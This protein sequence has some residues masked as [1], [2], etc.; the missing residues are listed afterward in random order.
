MIIN[1]G[2]PYPNRRLFLRLLDICV[3]GMFYFIGGVGISKILTSTFPEFIEE[4]YEKVNTFI[5]IGE[6]LLHAA[7][8][9]LFAYILRNLIYRI[10]IPFDG[11]WG[12]K[13]SKVSETKG[14]IIISFSI[15]VLLTD[16]RK[17]IIHLADRFE[18]F[19]VSDLSY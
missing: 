16:F 13:H 17:K 8:I 3:L 14:G 6:L 5:L 12:Y 15:F 7:L 1:D 19:K 18:L 11:L 9:M 4:E 2:K 10:P